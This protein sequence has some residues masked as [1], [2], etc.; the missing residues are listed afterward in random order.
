MEGGT[1]I[2]VTFAWCE[3]RSH[4]ADSQNGQFADLALIDKLFDSLMIPVF[5]EILIEGRKTTGFLGDV[6]YFPFFVYGV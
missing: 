6:Y 5:A 2:F 3:A 1:F 4:V